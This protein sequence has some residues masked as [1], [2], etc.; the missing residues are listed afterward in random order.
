MVADRRH[1]AAGFG[2]PLSPTGSTALSEQ[3][4]N[5]SHSPAIILAFTPDSVV[6]RPVENT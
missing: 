1:S 2:P 3:G 5:I 6:K 4:V